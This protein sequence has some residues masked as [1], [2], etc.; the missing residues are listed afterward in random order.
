MLRLSPSSLSSCGSLCLNSSPTEFDVWCRSVYILPSVLQS[1]LISFSLDRRDGA[2]LFGR[3]TSQVPLP[4]G[5]TFCRRFSDLLLMVFAVSASRM[6]SNFVRARPLAFFL[7]PCFPPILKSSVDISPHKNRHSI[8]R[9]P[10]PATLTL[11]PPYLVRPFIVFQ[12]KTLLNV[13]EPLRFVF[14]WPPPVV[15]AL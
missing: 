15:A 7:S 11:F 1:P 10:Q 13:V 5:F 3:E 2:F 6:I 14:S 12:K 4:P 9:P 8:F